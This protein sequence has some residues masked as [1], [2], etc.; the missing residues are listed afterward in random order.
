MASLSRQ[1]VRKLLAIVA[2]LTIAAGLLPASAQATT[3]LPAPTL[4]AS[5]VTSGV[6]APC[7][8]PACAVPAVIV[9]ANA[10]FSLT[11]TLSAAGAPA[12]FNKDTTLSLSATGGGVLTPTSI[13]MPGGETTHTFTG[14]TYSTYA[15]GV[16][17]TAFQ[18]GKKVSTTATPSNPFDVLQT[19][20]IDNASPGTPFQ[21]GSGPNDCSGISAADPVCG[22]LILPNGANS[23]VLMSTGS[24]VNIGCNTKGTVTQVIADLSSQPLY[25]STSPAEL[26]IRCYRTVCGSGGVNKYKAAAS[27][28]ATGALVTVPACPAKNTVGANQDFC[29]DYVSSTRANADEL[30]L[31]VL[32]TH[33]FR[34]SIG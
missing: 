20:K 4:I 12:A 9:A 23:N 8:P 1:R 6:T 28:S 27:L 29:T 15:N 19:L 31:V 16:T 24:C 13:T 25:S 34:G 2:G 14:L 32:F 10:P 33:D 26:L 21:D 3:N 7:G 5:A 30:D 11:V 22:V 17:V 18:S